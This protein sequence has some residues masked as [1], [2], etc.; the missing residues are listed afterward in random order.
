MHQFTPSHTKST[1]KIPA[2]TLWGDADKV[3]EPIGTNPAPPELVS[4]KAVVF[5]FLLNVIVAPRYTAPVG[6]GNVIVCD[7]AVIAT[8]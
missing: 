3:I 4:V 5:V 7:A 8:V 1:W 6:F 2:P